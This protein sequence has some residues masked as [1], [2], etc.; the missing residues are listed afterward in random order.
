MTLPVPGVAVD[1]GGP[2]PDPAAAAAAADLTGFLVR[3]RSQNPD[4]GESAMVAAIELW[5]E[6]FTAARTHRVWTAP[7]RP[8]LAAV[9]TG[10]KPGPTLVLNG[11]TDTVPAGPS[12]AWRL[13]PFAGTNDGT[14]VHGRGS[15][16]MK[17]GL[18][19]AMLAMAAASRAAAD[20]RG[21]LICHFAAGEERGEPGTASLLDAG[22]GGDLAVVLEPT[23]LRVG[24]ASRGLATYEILLGGR[25]GHAGSPGSTRSP[26]DALGI[27]MEALAR[28]P[29]D[30]PHALL[31]AGSCTATMVQA[32]LA[33]NAVPEQCTVVADRR[34]L[35]GERLDDDVA[36]L[37]RQLETVMPDG[38]RASVDVRPGAFPPAEFAA[39]GRFVARFRDAAS[40]FGGSAEPWGAPYACDLS[41][42]L[43]ACDE[44]VV[45]GPGR[46]EDAHRPDESVAIQQLEAA[47]Q[48][49]RRVVTQTLTR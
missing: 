42:F 10:S 24:T 45:F 41:R 26:L 22:F 13:D 31:P 18:A 4:D 38:V 29:A 14:A 16:D 12:G 23:E 28:H 5:L 19:V 48:T 36:R 11:H 15:C 3:I 40:R 47:V 6:R 35:P 21:T 34:L 30:A 8:S 39:D 2:L 43:G 32:G 44:A 46:I 20:L 9:L 17:A 1:H 25:G 27:C 33:P 7:G 37:E 49:V